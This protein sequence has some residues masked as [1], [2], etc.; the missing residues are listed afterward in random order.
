MKTKSLFGTLSLRAA[1]P[2]LRYVGVALFNT[3]FG[4]SLYSVS[5]FLFGPLNYLYSLLFAHLVSTTVAF[6][7]YRSFVFVV[8]GMI[9]KDYSRFQAVYLLA[10]VA[11]GFLLELI[12][13]NS[14]VGPYY[15][16]AICLVVVAVFSY[17]AHKHF[18]FRRSA[19]K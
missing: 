4:Y 12:V 6:F 17:L 7:L 5:L 9:L 1:G 2:Q 15:G 19:S 18:S 10:L 8:S 3:A 16:Q 13:R 14:E 11:N